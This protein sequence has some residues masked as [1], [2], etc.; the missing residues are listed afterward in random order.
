[1]TF[2]PELSGSYP[3]QGVDVFCSLL[4]TTTSTVTTQ[5]GEQQNRLDDSWSAYV[6]PVFHRT[7]A[8][9]PTKRPFSCTFQSTFG[10]LS[11]SILRHFRQDFEVSTMVIMNSAVFW[12]VMLCSLLKVHRRFRGAS[13]QPAVCFK[14]VSCSAYS[15]LKMEAMFCET[16]VDFKRTTRRYIPEYSTLHV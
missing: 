15:T 6:K 10:P 2:D 3:T 1:M 14:L 16:L 13:P 5:Q 8:V 9:W 7:P 4:H 12:D 11:G